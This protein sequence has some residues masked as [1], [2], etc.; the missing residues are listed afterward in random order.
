MKFFIDTNIFLNVLLDRDYGR[1]EEILYFLKLKGKLFISS[2]TIL[3]AI[4]IARKK[5]KDVKADVFALKK[6][7]NVISTTDEILEL[8]FQSNFKDFEDGVQYFCAKSVNCDLIIT[9]NKKDFIYSDIEI[10]DSIEF[11]NKFI[12][13]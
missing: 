5:L 2:T 13:G 6:K 10:M 12:K 3:N 9:D 11:Y 4:Y 8:S 1:S 7:F